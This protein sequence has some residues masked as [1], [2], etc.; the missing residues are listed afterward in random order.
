MDTR[1]LWRIAPP[2]QSSVASFVRQGI[3][4]S[5]PPQPRHF[6]SRLRR[7]G[8]LVALDLDSL[9]ASLLTAWIGGIFARRRFAVELDRGP[10]DDGRHATAGR[11]LFLHNLRRHWHC[12]LAYHDAEKNDLKNDLCRSRGEHDRHIEIRQEGYLSLGTRQT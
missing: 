5:A 9:D 10:M 2:M 7:R 12:L 8:D 4:A 11:G 3:E 1:A 6:L